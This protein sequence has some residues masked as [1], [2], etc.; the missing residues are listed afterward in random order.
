[1]DVRAKG[2]ARDAPDR[3]VIYISSDEESGFLQSTGR[4]LNQ[5]NDGDNKQVDKAQVES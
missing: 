1:M 5:S 2:G 4:R 3:H